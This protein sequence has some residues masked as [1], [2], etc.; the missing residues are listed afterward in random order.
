MIRS[1]EVMINNRFIYFFACDLHTAFF[2][3]TIY[4]RV[5]KLANR[6]AILLFI[7]SFTR[8]FFV[9]SFSSSGH[10]IYIMRYKFKYYSETPFGTGLPTQEFIILKQQSYIGT[11]FLAV[12]A[13]NEAGYG[14]TELS[15]TEEGTLE[16][17]NSEVDAERGRQPTSPLRGSEC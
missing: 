15:S 1:L 4:F 17:F 12:W 3:F 5:H 8:S 7:H 11:T 10:F 13:R 16:A 14:Q 9:I 2:N 6:H